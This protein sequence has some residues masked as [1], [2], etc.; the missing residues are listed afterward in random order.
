MKSTTFNTLIAAVLVAFLAAPAFA[1]SVSFK[2]T[3]PENTT[4][5]KVTI[6]VY[7]SQG[8]RVGGASA[9]I[10]PGM[11]AEQKRDAIK[12]ALQAQGFTVT[13]TG[14]PPQDPGII[15]SGLTNGRKVYFNPG[16]TGEH[17]DSET[18]KAAAFSSISFD[19]TFESTDWEGDPAVFTAGVQTDLGS[20]VVEY[21][22]ADVPPGEEIPGKLIAERLFSELLPAAEDLGAILSLDGATIK[23]S[24]DAAFTQNEGGVTFGTTSPGLGLSGGGTVGKP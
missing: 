5:C 13:S 17:K 24:F 16:C 18:A 2:F 20:A 3:K 1:G 8:N 10:T 11:T 22:A 23:V 15:I 14:T 4:N 7:D 12:A 19:G 21:Q 9:V 6:N